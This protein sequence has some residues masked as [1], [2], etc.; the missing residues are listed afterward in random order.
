MSDG[1]EK[2]NLLQLLP[3]EL[4]GLLE[5]LGEP[6]Y[7]ARQ[8]FAW[9]HR[10]AEF[11][12]MTDLPKAL[13]DRLASV[14]RTHALEPAGDEVAPDGA[15]KYGFQTD[16]EHIIETVLIPH[17]RRTTVCVSSQIGCA[18][19]C[20]FCAT[21][22]MGFIRD[23]TGAEIVEQVIRVQRRHRPERVTNLVFMGMGEP[24]ANYDAVMRAVRLLNHPD[25][26][27][28]GA[29]HIAISTCGIPHGIRRLSAEGLQVALAISL[30]AATD[31]VRKELAPVAR[32]HS[33][34]DVMAAARE[35]AKQTGRKVTFQYVVV[36]GVN[37]SREQASALA[38]LVRQMP[39]V[40]NLIPQ[41][42]LSGSG[43]PDRRAATRFEGLLRTR[44]VEVAVRRSRGAAVL[45]ACGQ[46]GARGAVRENAGRG[47]SRPAPPSRSRKES[48]RSAD[49]RYKHPV[50]QD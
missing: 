4:A 17:A 46:L 14:A 47:A 6:R 40:V 9:L 12:G 32:S 16:D 38:R 22:K 44:G 36:P 18:Y 7:R 23:L 49:Q 33:I 3:D 30:H 42:P 11:Q 39:S 29:R 13:R 35:F 21:G 37:D 48:H 28:I 27:G 41:N 31:E 20:R 43:R 50:D 10:G 24:L 25:G 8:I 15:A 34:A 26:L 1:D 2:A 19:G 45:G 5:D